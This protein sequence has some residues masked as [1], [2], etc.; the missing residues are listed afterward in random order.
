MDNDIKTSVPT[1]STTP[2]APKS[3]WKQKTGI[4]AISGAI[5]AAGGAGASALR[6][7]PPEPSVVPM[8]VVITGE[9]MEKVRVP[10]KLELRSDGTLVWKKGW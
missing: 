3:T 9:N 1:Y 2:S 10:I 4:A 7:K 8:A 6:D 5:G